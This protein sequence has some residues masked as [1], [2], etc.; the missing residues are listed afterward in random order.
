MTRNERY[1]VLRKNLI[2]LFEEHASPTSP[3]E[4]SFLANRLDDF[5]KEMDALA[6]EVV[7]KTVMEFSTIQRDSEL[8]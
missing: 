3:I 8:L 1:Q 5:A 2:E 7:V 6:A 4:V